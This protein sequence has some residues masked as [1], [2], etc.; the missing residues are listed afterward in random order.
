MR[1]WDELEGKKGTMDVTKGYVEV[2]N[3]VENETMRD[4]GEVWIE[5]QR[6]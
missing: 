4:L 1:T 3:G 2:N 5:R 6:N